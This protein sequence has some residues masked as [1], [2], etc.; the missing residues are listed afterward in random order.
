MLGHDIGYTVFPLDTARNHRRRK[1][2][3]DMDDVRCTPL[4][5]QHLEG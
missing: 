5:A 3:L 4:L 2:R 1:E